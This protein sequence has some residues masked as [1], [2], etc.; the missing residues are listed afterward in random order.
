MK[1]LAVHGLGHQE[2]AIASW[3]PQWIAAFAKAFEREG[4]KPEVRFAKYDEL[5]RDTPMTV[6]GTASGFGQL[7][8][9]EIR[10]GVSDAISSLWPFKRRGFGQNVNEAV[11]W[12]VGMVTQFAEDEGLRKRLREHLTNQIAAFQPDVV[13]AHSLGT[14]LTYNL[15]LNPPNNAIIKNRYYITAGCQIG[16]G[17]LRT[18]FGG[19]LETV[20]A[21]MWY[22]LYNV[23]DDVL[24][25][26]LTIYA[27]NYRQID[28]TFDIAGLADHDGAEYIKHEN[29]INKVWREIA[30]PPAVR[31]GMGGA[32]KATTKIAAEDLMETAAAIRIEER[33]SRRALLIGINDY[34]N[35]D[36][37]LEG[38]VNDVFRMSAALQHIGFESGEIRTVLNDR[39]TAAGIRERYAW[40]LEDPQPGDVRVLFFSGHGAQIP[41]YSA[42]ETVDHKDETLVAY[43]FDW[44]DRATHLADDDFNALYAQLPYQMTFAAFFDCCHSGGIARMGG[45]K[46]RGLNPPDD[47]RHRMLR[48]N[49]VDRVWEPRD[50]QEKRKQRNLSL[51][52]SDNKDYSGANGDV[53][54]K[55][56]GNELRQLEWK[57]YVKRRDK[58]GHQGPYLPLIFEACDEA[59]FA[60]EYRDGVTSYGAYT[61]FLTQAL[62]RAA[63]RR[64]MLTFEELHRR[65]SQL[66]GRYYDQQPQ[67][68]GNPMWRK[69]KI[70]IHRDAL[71]ANRKQPRK[72]RSLK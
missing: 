5:F 51:Y 62:F 53:F 48:W 55:F 6:G 56:R 29:A 58:Y 20:A 1:I 15:F 54:K 19:R 63:D 59:K 32:V 70:P 65:A 16:R 37:R 8:W 60:Y 35:P 69:T 67:L 18:I 40:L 31:R 33:Q 30:N 26:P 17:A 42:D 64:E 24:V 38:C 9:D 11:K 23:H 50:F 10:Y 52:T 2:A 72:P 3:Q 47:I 41:D 13:F 14:L 71:R 45:A 39:A 36:N 21:K 66:V 34:P 43:D 4:I 57:N 28:T 49:R 22:N 27:T 7:L 46:V 12:K 25:V 68:V 44:N 61:Y